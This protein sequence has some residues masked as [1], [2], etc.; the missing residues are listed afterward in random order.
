MKGGGRSQRSESEFV[1]PGLVIFAETDQMLL[2][3]LLS[4]SW[5]C[6]GT[7]LLYNKLHAEWMDC[8]K[9]VGVWA[10]GGLAN[11]RLAASNSSSRPAAS[12]RHL[13]SSSNRTAIHGEN[14]IET[15]CS[16]DFDFSPLTLVPVDLDCE[17]DPSTAQGH[18][19]RPVL[20]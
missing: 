12:T 20:L 18:Y 15:S 1:Q 4:A 17:T 10:Y 11:N 6:F 7:S 8:V 3:F 2:D 13:G 14:Q 19:I 16:T 5:T 9:G